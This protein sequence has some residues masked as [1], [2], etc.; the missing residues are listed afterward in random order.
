M[1]GTLLNYAILG[2]PILTGAFVGADEA[3]LAQIISVA[4][5]AV[6]QLVSRYAASHTCDTYLTRATRFSHVRR[7]RDVRARVVSR[8]G[9]W[10][11]GAAAL[12]FFWLGGFE[13][14]RDVAATWH[15]WWQNRG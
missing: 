1:P 4:S 3:E 12:G 10:G 14:E 8:R 15:S 9:G 11:F 13:W 6:L 2:I 5:F 7:A